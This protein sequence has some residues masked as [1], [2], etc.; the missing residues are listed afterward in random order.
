MKWLAIVGGVLLAALLVIIGYSLSGLGHAKGFG[1]PLQLALAS[2][3]VLPGG[4]WMIANRHLRP[5]GGCIIA[6]LMIAALAALWLAMPHVSYSA[7]MSV[8]TAVWLVAVLPFMRLALK[9]LRRRR[10]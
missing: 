10:L 4:Y 8:W 6:A 9:G 1:L 7:A 3:V 5:L 2:L